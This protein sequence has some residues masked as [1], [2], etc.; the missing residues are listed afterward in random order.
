MGELLGISLEPETSEPM[1]M[2]FPFRDFKFP[3]P[4]YVGEHIC[5]KNRSG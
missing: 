4:E 2:D 3:D 1:D 5:T